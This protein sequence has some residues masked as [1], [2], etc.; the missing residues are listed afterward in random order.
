M[1]EAFFYRDVTFLEPFL[2]G[3]L[4]VY[5]TIDFLHCQ[6]VPDHQPL[7]DYIPGGVG[8]PDF[9]DQVVPNRPPPKRRLRGLLYQF[10]S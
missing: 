1:V 7:L 3:N 2:E 9:V 5:S 10:L 8:D 6:A 4:G